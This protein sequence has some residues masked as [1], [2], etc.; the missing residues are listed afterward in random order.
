M[1]LLKIVFVLLCALAVAGCEPAP[2]PSA[3]DVSDGA[4]VATDTVPFRA[5]I[6]FEDQDLVAGARL[7]TYVVEAKFE[8]GERR[9]VAEKIV[10]V[11]GESSPM[12]IEIDVPRTE[13]NADYGYIMHA[14]IVDDAGQTLLTA[15]ANRAPVPATGLYFESVFNIRLL[16]VATAAPPEQV[17]RLPGELALDCGDLEIEV[18]QRADG[19][20]DLSL[21]D[22]EVQLAPA[23]ASAGGRFSDGARELWLTEDE[24]FFLLLPGEP[25]RTCVR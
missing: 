4:P 11:A 14:A 24:Q 23:V 3:T 9:L 22:A 17:F 2:A 25:P 8:D 10:P 19:R 1:S 18:R 21:P 5:R 20:V 16:P 12:M 15:A 6:V 7:A 13:L